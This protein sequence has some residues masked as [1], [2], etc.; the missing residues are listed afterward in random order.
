MSQKTNDALGH[1][2]EF[3]G[4]YVPDTLMTPLLEVA[5]AYEEARQDPDFQQE[6]SYYLRE[7]V[8][9]PTPLTYCPRLSEACGK[10][11]IY[12]KREDLAHTGSHK[13]NNCIGQGLLAKRMGR[14]KVMA[15][16]GAGQHGVAVATVAALLGME[17]DVYMGEEDT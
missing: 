4:I 13:I 6:L 9:R 3:G 15:E 17:C 14:K 1:F 11:K 5:E 2:G 7:Y 16:T 10:A 12:L 8:G